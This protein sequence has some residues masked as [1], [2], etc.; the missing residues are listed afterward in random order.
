LE[1][2]GGVQRTTF[3]LEISVAEIKGM[4]TATLARHDQRLDQHEGTLSQ[5]DERVREKGQILAR[6]DERI[7]DLEEDNSGR[8]GRIT[9][10]IGALV[11]VAALLWA[12]FSP[13]I[14]I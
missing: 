3:D 7:K 4:L 6:H 13:T 11:G 1:D 12:V 8:L 10:T 14:A 9:G 2:N 5:I